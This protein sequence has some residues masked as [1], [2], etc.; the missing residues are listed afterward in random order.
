MKVKFVCFPKCVFNDRLLIRCWVFQIFCMLS[1]NTFISRLAC[2]CSFF[3]VICMLKTWVVSLLHSFFPADTLYIFS[4]NRAGLCSFRMVVYQQRQMLFFFT[5][6]QN[7]RCECEL[8]IA[9]RQTRVF[10]SDFSQWR[11]N[12]MILSSIREFR[13]KNI[14]RTA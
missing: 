11:A 7:I 6:A 2:L 3:F 14:K 9:G 12:V 1:I 13:L 10:N 4:H 5:M 8:M